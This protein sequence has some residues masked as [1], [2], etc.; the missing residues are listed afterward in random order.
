VVLKTDENGFQVVERDPG[1]VAQHTSLRGK[2]YEFTSKVSLPRTRVSFQFSFL[3]GS[4]ENLARRVRPISVN[5]STE[6][7]PTGY[8]F[9]PAGDVG[10][11][12][13]PR[14]ADE[15]LSPADA[16]TNPWAHLTCLR[17]INGNLFFLCHDDNDLPGLYVKSTQPRN[18]ALAWIFSDSPF[19]GPVILLEI[20]DDDGIVVRDWPPVEEVLAPYEMGYLQGRKAPEVWIYRK[21]RSSEEEPDVGSSGDGEGG[22]AADP[23]SDS[24]AEDLD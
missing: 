3:R 11:I 17:H 23:P 4:L 19:L 1:N 18:K 24:E 7:T 12:E 20:D 8:L 13:L 16:S 9:R 5:M 2:R 21:R 22:S 15:L 6:K 10:L 14:T